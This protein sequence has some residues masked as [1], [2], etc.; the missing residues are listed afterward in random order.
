MNDTYAN[1]DLIALPKSSFCGFETFYTKI[2]YKTQ[3]L[4]TQACLFQIELSPHLHRILFTYKYIKYPDRNIFIT[5]ICS[6]IFPRHYLYFYI[7]LIFNIIAF[8]RVHLSN[9]EIIM[10]LG[11]IFSS[12]NKLE[13]FILS[14]ILDSNYRIL[15]YFCLKWLLILIHSDAFAV[16]GRFSHFPFI[17]QSYWFMSLFLWLSVDFNEYI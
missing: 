8:L 3:A 5:I 12:V 7:Q 16:F 1:A 10:S 13:I 9:N 11:R 17:W 2:K 6:I 14:F 15:C 4:C